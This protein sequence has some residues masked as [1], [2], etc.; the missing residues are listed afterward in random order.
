MSVNQTDTIDFIS[1]TPN[2]EVVLTISDHYS[3]VET[4]HLQLLQNKINAY[5]QFIES[6][7][8]YEDYPNSAGQDLI[9]ETVMKFEPNQEAI[10]FLEKAKEITTKAGIGFQWQVLK[11]D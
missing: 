11:A 2:G 10:S 1:T 4:R 6:G 8:I 9:I 5:L 7:Q 3:W